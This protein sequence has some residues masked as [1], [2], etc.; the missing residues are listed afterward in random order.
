MVT[1]HLWFWLSEGD[2]LCT[3]YALF[4]DSKL[5]LT[6][7]SR[8]LKNLKLICSFA[9][10]VKAIFC[11]H[12]LMLVLLGLAFSIAVGTVWILHYYML[13]DLK[14]SLYIPYGWMFGIIMFA[15][16]NLCCKYMFHDFHSFSPNRHK[17][18]SYYHELGHRPDCPGELCIRAHTRHCYM[19]RHG[20]RDFLHVMFPGRWWYIL[21]D[22]SV[23]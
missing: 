15:V 4:G 6:E 17:R 1:S 3:V 7:K 21:P 19:L 11:C 14:Y 9:V 22:G 20:P 10:T 18:H 5:T 23:K 13:N 16:F 8:L 2:R 12:W